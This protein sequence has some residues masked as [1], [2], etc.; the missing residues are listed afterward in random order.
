[1]MIGGY[2]PNYLIIAETILS[3]GILFYLCIY[4]FDNIFLIMVWKME[5]FH[6]N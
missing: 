4:V 5:T 6:I 1:M 2:L 3:Y